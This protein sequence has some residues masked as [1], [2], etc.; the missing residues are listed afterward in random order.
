MGTREKQWA[1]KLH[2][3]HLKKPKNK[4]K[5]KTQK[6][7]ETPKKRKKEKKEKKIAKKK[8]KNKEVILNNTKYKY[9]SSLLNLT[10]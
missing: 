1:V 5:K 2:R 9:Q 7:T 10:F 8:N 4:I 3:F 6:H